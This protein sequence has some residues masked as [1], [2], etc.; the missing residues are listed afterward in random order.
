MK[1]TI[2]SCMNCECGHRLLI[3]D[4]NTLSCLNNECSNYMIR[5]KLPTIEL[6]ETP[7]FTY[8][9]YEARKKNEHTAS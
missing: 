2:H 9:D 1:A 4:D 6:V 8:S 7:Y 5:F 3:N